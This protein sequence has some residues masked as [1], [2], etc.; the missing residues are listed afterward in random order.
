MFSAETSEIRAAFIEA[1][2]DQHPE[3]AGAAF[4]QWV[5]DLMRKTASIGY[6]EGVSHAYLR[7]DKGLNELFKSNP[8]TKDAR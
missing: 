5:E 4:D 3:E 8:Y 1:N 2:F 7:P 6:A